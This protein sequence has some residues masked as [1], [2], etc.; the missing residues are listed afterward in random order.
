MKKTLADVAAQTGYSTTT[1]SRALNGSKWVAPNAKKKI[2]NCARELGYIESKRTVMLI[3]P[4]LS[5]ASYYSDMV[6][7]LC[8]ILKSFDFLVEMVALD[9][10]VLIEEHN[11][12]GAISIVSEDGLEKYWGKQQAVPLV[13]INTRPKHLDGIF[14]VASNE[15]QG[16]RLVTEHLIKLGHQRICMLGWMDFDNVTN[17]CN[18]QRVSEF[19]AIM[20]S[21]GLNDYMV[22]RPH[23]HHEEYNLMIKKVIDAGVTAI[24]NPREGDLQRLI[25]QL[26]FM[27][28]KVP[29]DISVTGWVD[30][31]DKYFNPPITGVRQN[32]QYMA[33]HAIS[34]LL[35]L[36]NKEAV[37]EDC[38]MDYNFFPGA[39]TA[40]PPAINMNQVL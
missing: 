22:M 8:R 37:A 9:S 40:A 1:V 30:I 23:W 25:Y 28:K 5:G 12:C 6:G 14:T 35:K 36:L 29:K 34:M 33:T 26:E 20:E 4:N 3:V 16:T 2:L 10:L 19:K 17:Y 13:C 7:E 39:S 38:I 32:Y 15:Q 27:G 11:I 21:H 18:S 24:I 31:G